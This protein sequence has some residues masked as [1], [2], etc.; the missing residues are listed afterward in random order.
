MTIRAKFAYLLHVIG[1]LLSPRLYALE[2]RVAEIERHPFRYSG[3]WEAGSY[4]KGEFASHRGSLWFCH[5]P[6]SSRPGTDET[7]QLCVKKGRDGKDA[8]Q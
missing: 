2:Q 1:R 5:E 8:Q 3:A 7:W 4:D 6:T